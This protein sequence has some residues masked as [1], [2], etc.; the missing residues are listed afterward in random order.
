VLIVKIKI[1]DKNKIIILTIKTPKNSFKEQKNRSRVRSALAY[2]KWIC[3][4]CFHFM[5][6]KTDLA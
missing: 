6:N 3:L 4:L 2:L 5:Q 1:L